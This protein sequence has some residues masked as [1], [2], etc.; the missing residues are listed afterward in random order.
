MIQFDFG[1]VEMIYRTMDPMGILKFKCPPRR[2]A[3]PRHP[4]ACKKKGPNFVEDQE[5][6]INLRLSVFL[7]VD[8]SDYQ[9]NK[10]TAEFVVQTFSPQGTTWSSSDR[11]EAG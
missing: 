9:S 6:S 10:Q 5:M 1:K 4:L 2:V 3:R 8:C 7:F 11:S